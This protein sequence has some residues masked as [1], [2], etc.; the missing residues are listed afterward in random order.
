MNDIQSVEAH[1][2]PDNEGHFPSVFADGNP[3][4]HWICAAAAGGFAQDCLDNPRI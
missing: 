1:I 3:Q 2:H 4:K